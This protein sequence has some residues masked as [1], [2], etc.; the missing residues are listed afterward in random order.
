VARSLRFRCEQVRGSPV[1][2]WHFFPRSTPQVGQRTDWAFLSVTF[3]IPLCTFRSAITG[4]YR[5][6]CQEFI[7]RPC[8][9]FWTDAT[10]DSQYAGWV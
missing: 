1:V 9:H 10:W 2:N 7:E 3:M 8:E 5:T 6:A 4:Q